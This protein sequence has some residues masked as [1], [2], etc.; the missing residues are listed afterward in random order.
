MEQGFSIFMFFFAGALLL[1]AALMAVTKN[2]EMLPYRARI[3]VKP[4]DP[5]KYM[6]R[7]AKIV[8]LVALAVALG[9]AVALWNPA[10]GAA[11]MIAG[12]IAV[13]WLGTKMIGEGK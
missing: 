13:L 7:L 2:Y 10:V 1:Y 11:L 8:A 5:E 6:V 9:A 3:S 4:K 12:V